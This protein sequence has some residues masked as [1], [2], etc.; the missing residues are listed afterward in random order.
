MEQICIVINSVSLLI[1]TLQSTEKSEAVLQHQHLV[2]ASAH[3][4]M[5]AE[6]Q[7]G[8]P[9]GGCHGWL[10]RGAHR[11]PTG[12]RLCRCRWSRS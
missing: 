8:V 2:Q 5:D 10:H 11:H 4:K 12:Y 6:L 9:G 3:H 7:P 1:Q